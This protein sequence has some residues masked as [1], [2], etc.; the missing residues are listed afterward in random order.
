LKT[1]QKFIHAIQ[2]ET[3]EIIEKEIDSIQQAFILLFKLHINI[4]QL[5]VIDSFSLNPSS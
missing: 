1:I 2:N 3:P 4:Q 5:A